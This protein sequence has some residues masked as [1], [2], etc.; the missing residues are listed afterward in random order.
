MC[1]K[2]TPTKASATDTDVTS[3]CELRFTR[4]KIGSRICTRNGSPTQPSARLARVMPS[5]VAERYASRWLRTCLTKFARRFPSSI[6]ASSWL[7]RTLT[8]ANSHATKKPL[9]PTSAA[10]VAILPIKTPGESQCSLIVS[11]MGVVV[12]N[13]N[14]KFIT[15]MQ[16]HASGTPSSR[17][18]P[19][20]FGYASDEPLRSQL[21]KGETRNLKPSNKCPPPP[22]NFAAVH[23]PGGACVARQVRE[24]GVILFRPQL[25]AQCGILL[26]ACPLPLVTINPGSLGHK[27]N[28]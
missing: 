15:R 1:R 6:K 8:T 3:P 28:A 14:R 27:L 5:W 11:A 4:A 22:R 23:D 24:A 9:S 25:R 12:R 13:K 19:A 16:P 17:N 7:P 18:L 26:H 21:A 2:V 20:R 10:I